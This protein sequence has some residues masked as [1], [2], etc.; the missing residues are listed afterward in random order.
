VGKLL[1]PPLAAFLF[2]GALIA[3]AA[4]VNAAQTPSYM[5][6]G[7]SLAF[8]V[9]ADNPAIGGYVALTAQALR[10]SDAFRERG[11]EMIN[12]SA[13]GATSADLL[14][15]GGQVDRAKDQIEKRGQEAGPG[16]EVISVGI[17]GND[18]LALAASDSPCL[19]DT[20]SDP[21]RKLIADMLS[22]LQRNLRDTLSR[23]RHAAPDAKIYV[24]DLYNPYSGTGDPR[25][26]I[27]NVA[28]QQVNGVISAVTLDPDL[29][30][31]LLQVYD[32][33]K[34][35]GKQWIAGD[36]I[37]PNND[38]HRVLSEAL[39]AS[40]EERAVSLP[41]DLAA[42]PAESLPA[43]DPGAAAL[44]AKSSSND[45]L[46]VLA[47]A[48]PIAFLAGALLSATYFFARGRPHGP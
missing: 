45:T 8:G 33:F 29:D 34:G 4:S 17:G 16:I 30:A 42:L 32:L 22:S 27:A 7:D 38:G 43:D 41:A 46:L 18:L 28:V 11:L 15:A 6:L 21:C 47:I 3:P 26:L 25:E 10:K 2:F 37:H 24:M 9:G 19:R 35:H 40:V 1:L 13:P 23:L 39:L 14:L 12:L 5:A 44:A 20:A 36:G 31:R 48:L